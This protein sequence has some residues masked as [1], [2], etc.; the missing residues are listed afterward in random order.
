MNSI[1]SSFW[2]M[3]HFLGCGDTDAGGDL[4]DTAPAVVVLVGVAATARGG[5]AV[6]KA[7]VSPRIRTALWLSIDHDLNRL[8]KLWPRSSSPLGSE[9]LAV[10]F[11]ISRSPTASFR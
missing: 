3:P 6:C 7:S 10:T 4:D 2:T 1:P 8:R 5:S 9:M 11:S